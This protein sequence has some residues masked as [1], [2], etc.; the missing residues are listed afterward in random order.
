MKS[1]RSDIVT[2]EMMFSPGPGEYDSPVRIGYNA[3]SVTIRGRP[4]DIVK[5][6]KPGPGHYDPNAH[7][8]KDKVRAYKIDQSSRADIV[9]KEHK[10]L[11]GPGIYEQHSTIG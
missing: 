2:K 3:Q 10:N 5:D 11:P 8:V 9:S 4:E 1:K 7:A 6:D